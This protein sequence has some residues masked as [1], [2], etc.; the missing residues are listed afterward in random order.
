MP[1]LQSEIRPGPPRHPL[2]QRPAQR[3]PHWKILVGAVVPAR[4]N[5][6][7]AAAKRLDKMMDEDLT[8]ARDRELLERWRGIR[9]GEKGE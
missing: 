5:Q 6:D 9:K 8:E 7:T 1:L 4:A 3:D 2:L